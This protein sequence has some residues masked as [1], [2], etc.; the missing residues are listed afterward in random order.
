MI[1]CSFQPTFSNT[2]KPHGYGYI[3]VF[4]C[5]KWT[6]IDTNDCNVNIYYKSNTGRLD[7]LIQSTDLKVKGDYKIYLFDVFG[8]KIMEN[9]ID[10]PSSFY[11]SGLRQGFYYMKITNNKEVFNKVIEIN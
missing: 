5:K 2:E 9:T 6:E 8:R 11:K 3:K 7:I 10:V 1:V 4:D